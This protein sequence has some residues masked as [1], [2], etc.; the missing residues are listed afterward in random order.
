MWDILLYLP[1]EVA[2]ALKSKGKYYLYAYPWANPTEYNEWDYERAEVINVID[3]D[4]LTELTA[5]AK[6]Y[7]FS[8]IAEIARANLNG[9]IPKNIAELQSN[10]IKFAFKRYQQKKM[11]AGE[12]IDDLK[13]CAIIATIPDSFWPAL[14]EHI[15][16]NKLEKLKS[17]MN[18]LS[19]FHPKDDDRWIE[20][21]AIYLS[22]VVWAQDDFHIITLSA[23]Q[24]AICYPD[25]VS[26]QALIELS[27]RAGGLLKAREIEAEMG[28]MKPWQRSS[29]SLKRSVRIGPA[30]AAY[31][32]EVKKHRSE[33]DL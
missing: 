21:A 27:Q 15:S 19:I 11:T 5:R 33:D 1:S 9:K 17:A 20:R 22:R 26:R 18:S 24:I 7:A 8:R 3:G 16:P 14:G 32:K 29:P 23:S 6:V 12:F 25:S 13:N 30:K 4:L 10:G 2:L 31:K 28:S